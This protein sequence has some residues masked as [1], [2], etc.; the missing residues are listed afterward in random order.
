MTSL[1]T[2]ESSVSEAYSRTGEPGIFRKKGGVVDLV[3][4]TTRLMACFAKE[5]ERC[6]AAGGYEA[7]SL[8]LKIRRT[9]G[10]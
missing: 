10:S 6:C 2:V 5:R 3:K 9:M 1:C 7:E 4:V 8:D